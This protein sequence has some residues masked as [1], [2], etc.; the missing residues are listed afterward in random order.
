MAIDMLASYKQIYFFY[1][2]I[3]CMGNRSLD[4][5]ILGNRLQRA[6]KS[7]SDPPRLLV[8]H[9]DQTRGGMPR[10]Y[11]LGAKGHAHA[12]HKARRNAHAWS[13]H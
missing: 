8:R 11:I 10:Y 9:I 13:M 5:F 3:N 4:V 6:P 2:T 12:R 1:C 7:A